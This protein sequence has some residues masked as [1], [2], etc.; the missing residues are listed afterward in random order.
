ML[1]SSSNLEGKI[2]MSSNN[3]NYFQ[4][5]SLKR[6][7]PKIAKFVILTRPNNVNYFQN[8]SLKRGDAKIADL[9]DVV[10]E[11]ASIISRT[12]R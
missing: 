10:G 12:L 9:L 3:I 2:C 1:F 11:K 6:G 7:Y 8:T 5:T 4:N